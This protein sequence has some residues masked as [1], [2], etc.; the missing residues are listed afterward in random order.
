MNR[1]EDGL[2]Y[3]DLIRKG[4]MS[5]EEL[6]E[7]SFGVI[8]ARN[9]ELNAVIHTRKEEALKEAAQREWEGAPFGGV[10]ILLKGLGQNM[11]GEPA[12]SGS[13][14]FKDAKATQTSHFVTRLKK[15]GFIPIGSTN[16]PEFGFTNITHSELYGPA[17]NPHNPNYSAGG[18]SGG[19]SAAVASGM[20]PIAGAS[21]G[22]GSIR[23]PASFTG[24]VGLKPTRGRMPVG[25]GSGRDWQGAAISFALTKTVRDSAALLDAMQVLQASAAFQTPLFKEGYMNYLKKP[26]NKPF[27]IA[28][29]AESPVGSKV[30]QD[31]KE[32]LLKV[33]NW[34]ES[35]GFLVEEDMPKTD[36]KELMRAYY[37]MNSGETAAMIANIERSRDLSVKR[38]DMELLTWVLY[39]AGKKTSAADYSNAISKWD[40]GAEIVE[41][42]HMSYDLYIQPA[43]AETAPKVD[44]VYW[45]ETLLKRMEEVET[46]PADQQ[47]DLIRDMWDESLAITPFS[48]QA[49]L[50]GQPSISLP[51]HVNAE[52][53]PLGIQITAAKGK[54]HLLLKI[55]QLM[56]SDGLF[57]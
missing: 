48:Q 35:S 25:P 55:A 47:Q 22:G 17:R 16:I 4:E 9:S 11:K 36:G 1:N 54:E 18:S 53:L 50:T 2:Y 14:L 10:P 27:K 29:S 23:I 20:V 3:A 52:G 5:S 49:N 45:D 15:A 44:H 6:I 12:T 8:E 38:E 43:T 51:V 19:A 26:L 30:S 28:Y 42:F 33:V 46:L 57:S 21:D 32:A 24:L 41:G 39:Q 31:A 34:L 13:R 7:Q 40:E 56:E 37:T